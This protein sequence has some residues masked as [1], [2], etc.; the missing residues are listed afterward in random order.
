[1][2]VKTYTIANP[3]AVM[4]H[5]KYTFIAYRAVVS[6]WRLGA[7]ALPAYAHRAFLHI[8]RFFRSKVLDILFPKVSCAWVDQA[9]HGKVEDNVKTN[10][11][12]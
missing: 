4:V 6:P 2:V 10:L 11:K 8:L 3:R 12:T 9:A 1:L 5:F 7:Q